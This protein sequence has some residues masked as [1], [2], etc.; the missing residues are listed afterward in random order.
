MSDVLFFTYCMLNLIGMNYYAIQLTTH[1]ERCK[2]LRYLLIPVYAYLLEENTNTNFEIKR[3]DLIVSML[4]LLTAL[5][6]IVIWLYGENIPKT[7]GIITILLNICIGIIVGIRI[8]MIFRNTSET[9]ILS[10]YFIAS[11][12]WFIVPLQQFAIIIAP[13]YSTFLGIFLKNQYPNL[14][15]TKMEQDFD[16]YYSKKDNNVHKSN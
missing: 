11:S 12:I 7:V 13:I 1:P 14:L 16:E 10:T 8:P 6:I 15:K 4:F 9:M 3:K 5:S 2:K